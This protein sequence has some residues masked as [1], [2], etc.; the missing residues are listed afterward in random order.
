MAVAG[1]LELKTT[2]FTG[3]SEEDKACAK[4]FWQSV[5][6]HPTI[7]SRLVSGDIRQRLPV[8]PQPGQEG[9]VNLSGKP[10][11]NDLKLEAHLNKAHQETIYEESKKLTNQAL[12]RDANLALLQKRKKERISKETLS[13]QKRYYHQDVMGAVINDDEF[14]DEDE[15]VAETSMKALDAFEKAKNL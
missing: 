5:T 12:M 7:E 10:Q 4:L 6:L 1:I 14:I 9:E 11:E 2:I 8:A 3:S 15:D 13:K